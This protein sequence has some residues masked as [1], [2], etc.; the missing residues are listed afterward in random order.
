M[1]PEKK[2]NINALIER[3]KKELE[4]MI[5]MHPQG[6]VLLDSAGRIQRVNMT[7]LKMF[8]ISSFRTVLG[9]PLT[10]LIP[11][12]SPQAV[13]Q[14]LE[15]FL[16]EKPSS[17][18]GHLIKELAFQFPGAE[19]RV[20][21][22]AAVATKEASA[23]K[24]LIVEEITEQKAAEIDLEKQHK[25]QAAEELTGA[26][27]HTINQPLTVITV[28]CQLLLLAIEKGNVDPTEVKQGL[29][30]ISRLAM[31]IADTIGKAS[32]LSDFVT[33]PY[34]HDLQIVDLD[35]STGQTEKK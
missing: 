18:Q 14:E 16:Q 11:A 29:E 2:P 3:A 20:F 30:E 28:R 19:K 27:M 6:M 33:T 10:N 34:T 35:R 21:R 26:L 31:Q 24:I 4:H 25:L 8:G 32:S 22:F 1:T 13:T 5:D 9:K 23:P 7:A 15:Q 12:D 17:Q